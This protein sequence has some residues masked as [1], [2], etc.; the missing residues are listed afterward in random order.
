MGRWIA[1]FQAAVVAGL[2]GLEQLFDPTLDAKAIWLL[3]KC[4]HQL[5]GGIQSQH[6]PRA[7]YIPAEPQAR[8]LQR[9]W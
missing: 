5:F 1:I 3:V 4:Q 2:K 6:G 8:P 9:P 7:H